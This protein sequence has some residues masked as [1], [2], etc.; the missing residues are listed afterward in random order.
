MAVEIYAEPDHRPVVFSYDQTLV[1]GE[2]VNI[3]A[4]NV[5]TQD[6]GSRTAQNHGTFVLFYPADF[7][8]VD[9]ITVTG[10]DGGED[11]GTVTIT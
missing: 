8:G 10:S 9:T 5:D 11:V 2:T 4:E 3:R 7:A 6:V 1:K